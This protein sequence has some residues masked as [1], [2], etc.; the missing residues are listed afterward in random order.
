MN[1]YKKEW[2]PALT[3]HTRVPD[4]QG[5]KMYITDFNKMS[6]KQLEFFNKDLGIE[7]VIEDGTIISTAQ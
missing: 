1:C 4:L 7:F 6:I 5:G 2:H 3:Y